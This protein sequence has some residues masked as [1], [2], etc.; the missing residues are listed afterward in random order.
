MRT[1]KQSNS[2][3]RELLQPPSMESSKSTVKG[4][5]SHVF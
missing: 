4:A 5:L 3:L 1:V 2:L